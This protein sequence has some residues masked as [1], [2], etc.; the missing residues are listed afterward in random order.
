MTVD[1]HQR[2]AI[3]FSAVFES[4]ELLAAWNHACDT[5][6][7]G[8]GGRVLT[9]LSATATSSREKSAK[10]F[11]LCHLAR[12][13][14]VAKPEELTEAY[15]TMLLAH[16]LHAYL[17]QRGGLADLEQRALATLAQAGPTF[18]PPLTAADLPPVDEPSVLSGAAAKQ[19]RKRV[20]E[21]ITLLEAGDAAG[22]IKSLLHPKRRSEMDAA[23]G[24]DKVAAELAGSPRLA[25]LLAAF[26]WAR[27]HEA[28][29]DGN[30]RARFL[31]PVTAEPVP[32]QELEFE[33]HAGAWYL[34]R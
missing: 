30:G 23:G 8:D 4:P 17:E 18:V 25:T 33:Q 19:L 26:K 5:G 12:R 1:A 6:R 27:D 13:G 2:A 10:L 21:G 29:D 11:G 9:N 3:C 31:L 34:D 28:I 14:L 16:T 7:V 20:G 24:I 22:F 15:D 32:R